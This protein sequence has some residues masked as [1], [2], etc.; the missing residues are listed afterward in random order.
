MNLL[1][2]YMNEIEKH[3]LSLCELVRANAINKQCIMFSIPRITKEEEERLIEDDYET[4]PVEPLTGTAAL[5][6]ALDAFKDMHVYDG[7]LSRRFVQKYPGLIPL[8]CS[9]ETIEPYVEALNTAKHGFK[10]EVQ[11]FEGPD[12]KFYEVHD[13]FHYL[14]TTMAY[15]KVYA[16]QGD[17]KAFYFNWSRR[18]RVETDTKENWLERLERARATVP[19]K[20]SRES[21]YAVL[22]SERTLLEST[23]GEK[24]SARRP[25][26]LR[27]E[28]S[29]RNQKGQMLGYSAGMPFLL[30]ENSY[31]PKVSPLTDYI[32]KPASSN[33]TKWEL[34]LPRIH[35][36]RRC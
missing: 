19:A 12:E 8:S 14:I 20:Y 7:K 5:E 33:S 6:Y 10:A 29:V 24:F 35:L 22:D 13:R 15:R 9:W 25:I 31:R 28:C 23:P 27:P 36:Y 34:I 3:T 26:K 1:R 30:T 18:P 4:I 21:W 11:K 32:R 16:F 2:F 17:Y